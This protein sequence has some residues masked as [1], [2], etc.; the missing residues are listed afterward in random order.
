MCKFDFLRTEIEKAKADRLQKATEDYA[1]YLTANEAAKIAAGKKTVTDFAAK[2]EK[3]SCAYEINQLAKL[4]AAEKCEKQVKS[5]T[6]T[7]E[8]KKSQMWGNNPRATLAVT[9]ANNAYERYESES[10]GGCGYDKESTAI[11]QVLN[12]VTALLREM[13]AVKNEAK[14]NQRDCLGYGSG[15]GVLPYFE[16]GVGFSCHRDILEKLGFDYSHTSSGK[17]FDVYSFSR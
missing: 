15:Y 8:W 17:R 9:Y 10:I 3:K 16:G 6:I 12:Q 13:Y 4:E 7:V 1:Q 11:G 2:I 5:L 14:T